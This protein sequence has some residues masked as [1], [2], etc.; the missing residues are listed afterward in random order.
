MNGERSDVAAWEE[1]GTNNVGIRAEC[2]PRA[3]DGKNRPVVQRIEKIVTKLR[4]DQL[5]DQLLAQL[6]SAAVGEND[7]AVV[8]DR[9]RACA[10]ERACAVDRRFA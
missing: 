10:R 2:E 8:R 1:N 3:V 9:N 4:K 6:P 7:L 5:L